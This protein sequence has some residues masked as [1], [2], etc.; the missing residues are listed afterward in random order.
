MV[1]TVQASALRTNGK[2]ARI[3]TAQATASAAAAMVAENAAAW[4]KTLS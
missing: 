3:A 1:A 2:F 4:G